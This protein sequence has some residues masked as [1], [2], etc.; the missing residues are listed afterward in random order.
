[1]QPYLKLVADGVFHSY[2]FFQLFEDIRVSVRRLFV[3]KPR[4]EKKEK[5]LHDRIW[6]T[7]GRILSC[8]INIRYKLLILLKRMLFSLF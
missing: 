6:R 7:M 1:M 2:I 5:I 3:I 4:G 8:S